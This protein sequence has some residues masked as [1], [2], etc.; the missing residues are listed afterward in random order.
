M[1]ISEPLSDLC[2]R[3]EQM[4]IRVTS[5]R[6][7]II[8]LLLQYRGKHVT[9][10]DMV[11]VFKRKPGVVGRATVYRTLELLADRQV[12]DKHHFDNE[13]ARY[14][15][16]EPDQKHAYHQLLC[17][18]C[19]QARTIKE[20]WLGELEERIEQIHG[21]RVLDHHLIFIGR[22]NNSCDDASRSMAPRRSCSCTPFT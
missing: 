13:V 4:G 9:A 19:K 22:Y 20:D 5:Q 10:D 12:I 15:L 17:S 11:A 7:A 16:R 1:S 2:H 14:E 8:H 6:K 18:R 21:F 3:I